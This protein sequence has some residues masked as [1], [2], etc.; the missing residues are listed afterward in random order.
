MV[1]C[2]REYLPP[3]VACTN[4]EG[5]M[6]LWITLPKGTSSMQLFDLAI[7][8]KVAF[9][10]GNPFYVDGRETE[11]LRLNFSCVDEET[12]EQGI[13]RLAKSLKKLIG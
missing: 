4:P 9:V 2:I 12:I 8:D 5:G 3:E 11:T 7:Q 10:P 6:F 1:S 13:M